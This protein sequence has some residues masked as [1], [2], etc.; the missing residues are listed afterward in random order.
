MPL[1]CSKINLILTKYKYT[2]Y[3]TT[4]SVEIDKVAIANIIK[5]YVIVV[6]L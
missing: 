1:I 2:K 3:I 4:N 5:L 6:T